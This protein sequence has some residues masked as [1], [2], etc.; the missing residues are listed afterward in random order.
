MRT[1]GLLVSAGLLAGCSGSYSDLEAAFAQDA[2]NAPVV[3][4]EFVVTSRKQERL[5]RFAALASVRPSSGRIDLS[6]SLSWRRSV[7]IPATEVAYCSMTCFGTADPH[8]DLLIPR[9]GSLI[10]IRNKQELLDWCWTH[11]IPILSSADKRRW[12]YS[13]AS[14]PPS[15]NYAT[16]FDDRS[17]FDK[18][19]QQSCLGY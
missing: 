16:Q 4:K 11:R 6:P 5:E 7:S 8:V 19:A 3:A 17:A 13:G 14:L 2:S 18:Q 15:S 12:L 9:T 10:R 1:L